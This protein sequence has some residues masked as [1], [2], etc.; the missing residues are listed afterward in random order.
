[1]T[2]IPIVPPT[3]IDGHPVSYQK[4]TDGSET[5][6][7]YVADTH[8]ALKGLRI[9]NWIKKTEIDGLGDEILDSL[10]KTQS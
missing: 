9:M 5:A 8:P 2:R 3:H 7:L 1:M 4:N 6:D 10:M